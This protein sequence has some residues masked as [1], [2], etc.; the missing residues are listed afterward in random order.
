MHQEG[1]KPV[2]ILYVTCKHWTALFQ[3][4]SPAIQCTTA[5]LQ[6]C[7]VLKSNS[8]W[9]GTPSFYVQIMDTRRCVLVL[10]GVQE[11]QYCLRILSRSLEAMWISHH[12][13]PGTKLPKPADHN[14][15]LN[16]VVFYFVLHF[17]ANLSFT[18]GG[19]ITH[20]P[21]HRRTVHLD[22]LKTRTVLP[23]SQSWL[24]LHM[25]EPLR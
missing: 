11:P 5:L 1:I 14:R 4:S 16:F 22:A 3:T 15:A 2:W 6:L 23:Y 24:L 12:R 21:C 9:H 25:A 20:H 8:Q 19:W 18:T 10:R 7:P 13:R 17:F